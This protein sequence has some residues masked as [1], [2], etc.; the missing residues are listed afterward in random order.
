MRS[1]KSHSV[2]KNILQVV[3]VVCVVFVC[4]A[5]GRLTVWQPRCSLVFERSVCRPHPFSDTLPVSLKFSTHNRMDFRS[6]TRYRV[7]DL[8][9]STERTLHRYDRVSRFGRQM[10]A[11]R[12]TTPSLRLRSFVTGTSQLPAR[13]EPNPNLLRPPLPSKCPTEIME[14][15][16]PHAVFIWTNWEFPRKG[17]REPDSIYSGYS[18]WL[19]GF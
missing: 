18:K 1:F 6:G 12:W 2:K 7:G 11:A 17:C 15:I 14:D 13:F 9:A 16:L 10:G 3:A 19:S 5:T 8:V 4:R